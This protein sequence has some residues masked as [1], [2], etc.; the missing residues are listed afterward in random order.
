M[1]ARTSE[2]KTIRVPARWLLTFAALGM[3]LTL[4][5]LAN[6][7]RA[8]VAQ[9][10]LLILES[11]ISGG[12]TSPEAREARELGLTY[13]IATPAALAAKTREKRSESTL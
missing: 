7:G 13:E 8:Q 1:T 3:C 5:G 9:A 11:T 6:I 10:D 4:A 12:E 2:L